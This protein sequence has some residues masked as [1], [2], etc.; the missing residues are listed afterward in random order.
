MLKKRILLALA[1]LA[2][3]V[4]LVGLGGTAAHAL[5]LLETPKTCACHVPGHGGGGGGGC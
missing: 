5:G 2:L 4:S 3:L 1:S